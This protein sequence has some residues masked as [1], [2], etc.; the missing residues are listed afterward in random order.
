MTGSNVDA[1]GSAP[2]AP[3][4]DGALPNDATQPNG[5]GAGPAAVR[6][7]RFLA[8][9]DAIGLGLRQRA[10]ETAE[11]TGSAESRVLQLLAEHNSLT[12]PQIARLRGTSRQNIQ[13]VVNRLAAEKCLVFDGNPSHKRSALVHLTDQGRARLQ[14]TRKQEERF[15]AELS[16]R[17][18]ESDLSTGLELLQR[19]REAFSD[20]AFKPALK[21]E[22]ER[23]AA[24]KSKALTN[25]GSKR[26]V[27][28][29]DVESSAPGLTPA[30]TDYGLPENLL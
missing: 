1:P 4:G 7:K 5:Y 30:P 15:E 22:A 27:A 18:S 11:G 21:A 28:T 13:I 2:D 12:V 3:G 6:L 10:G 23:T 25:R 16:A 29:E 26:L 20:K 8:E 9:L 24:G 14:V 19:L 17:L